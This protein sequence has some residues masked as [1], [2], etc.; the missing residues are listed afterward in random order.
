MSADGAATYNI[1]GGH[2][3]PLQSISS[4]QQK[5]KMI[6]EKRT[7]PSEA[8][9][10]VEYELPIPGD[11]QRDSAELSRVDVGRR[12]IKIRMVQ[13]IDCVE[14][15]FDFFGFIDFHALDQVGIERG[16]RWSLEPRFAQIPN[17]SWRRIDE[18]EPSLGIRKRE[19]AIEVL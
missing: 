13:Y 5:S 11:R 16:S 19:I 9:P 3:P 10:G 12:V 8:Q 18:K 7:A 17:R 15:N 2:R 6:G 1:A 14:T 4:V